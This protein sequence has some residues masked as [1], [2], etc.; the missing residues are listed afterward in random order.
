MLMMIKSIGLHGE[1][2]MGDDDKVY[3][4]YENIVDP[5]DNYNPGRKGASGGSTGS[6]LIDAERER[7]RNDGLF[8]VA[9]DDIA[10]TDI[11]SITNIDSRKPKMSAPQ[12]ILDEKLNL[13][14]NSHRIIIDR[15]DKIERIVDK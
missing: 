14:I 7:L 1:N 12:M 6:A 13:I 15:L 11:S 4:P 9:V 8:G 10:N 3:S 2:L 5:V